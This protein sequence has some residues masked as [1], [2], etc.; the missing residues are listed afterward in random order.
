MQDTGPEEKKSL[1]EALKRVQGNVVLIDSIHIKC[2]YVLDQ[3]QNR[4]VTDCERL[5]EDTSELTLAE[6][7]IKHSSS[8]SRRI[9]EIDEILDQISDEI[10]QY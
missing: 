4:K 9:N 2:K 1:V 10:G 3:I 7:F 8:I 6:Q 5:G